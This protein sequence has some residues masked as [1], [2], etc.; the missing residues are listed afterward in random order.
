MFILPEDRATLG[1]DPSAESGEY[2]DGQG[3][4]SPA[5]FL[6]AH[7]VFPKAVNPGG[8]GAEPPYKIVPIPF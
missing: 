5:F 8:L 7:P 3:D 4:F 2:T 6:L 1:S